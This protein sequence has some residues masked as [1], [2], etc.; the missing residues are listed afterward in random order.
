MDY[1]KYSYIPSESV[2]NTII[3][4]S[5][6]KERCAIQI[7]QDY[8]PGLEALTPLHYTSYKKAIKIYKENDWEELQSTDRMFFRKAKSGISDTLIERLENE[9]RQK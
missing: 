9:V 7:E 3:F 2:V 4:N 8:Y 5:D 1:F 6:Y